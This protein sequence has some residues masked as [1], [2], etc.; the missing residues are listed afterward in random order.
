MK[1][2]FD[3]DE[4]VVKLLSKSDAK[5]SI[6]GG[7]YFQNDRPG[8]SA[9]EDIVVN[10]ISVSQEYLPQTAT[11][12]VNIYVPD[13]IRKI[14]GVERFMPNNKRLS[15]LSKVVLRVLRDA[16]LD[17]LKVISE[18]Q[19]VLQEKSI[20]QHFVNIRITWNIQTH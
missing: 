17:G 16:R 20:N 4:M 2:S 14:G 13:V 6:S 8:D 18:S 15:E 5:K 10:T 11:G 3:L 7:I 19:S 9:K 12:N 1:T